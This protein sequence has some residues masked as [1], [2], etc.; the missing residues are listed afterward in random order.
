MPSNFTN[1]V[2]R[3]QRLRRDVLE[4]LLEQSI[5]GVE[6]DSSSRHPP[7]RCHPG[8]CTALR[9]TIITRLYISQRDWTVMWLYGTTDVGK[10]AVAQTVA[11]ECREKDVLGAALFFSKHIRSNDAHRIIP[12][13]AYQLANRYSDYRALV[14]REIGEDPRLFGG[15]IRTQ[16]KKLIAVPLS[17]LK[18]RGSLTFREPKLVI[19]DGLDECE[20][21]TEAQELIEMICQHARLVEN[22]PLLW[23]IC[24]RPTSQITSA[25]SKFQ[26]TAICRAQELVFDPKE[27]LLPFLDRGFREI[28]LQHW[29]VFG[30]DS[31]QKWPTP[32]E[33]RIIAHNCSGQFVFGSA[34][35]KYVA[36]AHNPNPIHRLASFLEVMRN[37]DLSQC[38]TN[39]L[40][41]LDLLYKHILDNLP[42]DYLPTIRRILGV[43]IYHPYAA[44]SPRALANF[45]HLDQ[46]TFETS[47]SKLFSVLAPPDSLYSSKERLHFYHTSFG[48]F[49]RDPSRSAHHH[50]S[51]RTVYEDL[52]IH[53]LQWSNWSVKR[54]CARSRDELVDE[55]CCIVEDP[56]AAL[57]WKLE[58]EVH[59]YE[60]MEA[61][62]HFASQVCWEACFRVAE[63]D[64]TPVY[65]EL[66]R[67][68]H[69]PRDHLVRFLKRYCATDRPQGNA[70]RLTVKQTLNALW[71]ASFTLIVFY[72][73]LRVRIYQEP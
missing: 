46:P 64:G 16:F 70:D 15:D 68:K 71:L 10:S 20:P 31:N 26:P 72:A 24:S 44:L 27:D 13:V 52:A 34:L 54:A 65:Q 5:K 18:A 57:T 30:S 19:L 12:T 22:S 58:D 53:S 4:I 38:R 39:P 17:S 69:C 45:L 63:G 67:I 56:L 60:C 66:L 62:E 32:S 55:I 61:V 6:L 73:L 59:S 33:L 3:T 41:F 14:E 43:C 8:T 48:N 1:V 51:E 47:I 7:P 40:F 49:L 21:H 37:C 9:Q 35:L 36:D 2:H 23:V 11:E 50:I 42:N 28:R 25:F 29:E